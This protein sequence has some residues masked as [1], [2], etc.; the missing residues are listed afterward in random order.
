[1][2]LIHIVI[3]KNVI[4][5]QNGLFNKYNNNIY[6]TYIYINISNNNRI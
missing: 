1:M 6:H 4:I 2:K 5:I 3:M